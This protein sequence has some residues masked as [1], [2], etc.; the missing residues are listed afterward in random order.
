M[1]ISFSSVRLQRACL[2]EKQS[3]RQWGKERAAKIRLRIVQIRA[4]SSLSVLMT[5]PGA[6]CHALKGD[7]RGQFAVDALYPFRLIFEPD[8]DPIPKL[9]DGGVDTGKITRIEILEVA[10]YH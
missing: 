4:A 6:K 3:I 9:S 1:T 8:H 7:R 5:V 2:E 10:D